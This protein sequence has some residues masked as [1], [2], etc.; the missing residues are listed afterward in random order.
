MSASTSEQSSLLEPNEQGLRTTAANTF[1][2][3]E[4]KSG[5][6]AAIFFL[7]CI[8]VLAAYTYGVFAYG[9]GATNHAQLILMTAYGFI[10]FLRLNLM[11]LWLLKRELAVE[12]LT[13]VILIW[14][15]AILSSFVF[16]LNETNSK[17]VLV[18][19]LA[20]YLFGSFLN[21]YS[22]LERKWWKSKPE[23]QG[24]CYMDGL[25]SWS[26]NINY[27]GDTLL[28][29]GWALA[30]ASWINAWVPVVMGSSFIW[31][32]IPDKETYLAKRYRADW[33]TYTQNTPYAFAPYI[34]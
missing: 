7:E 10:Y 25:F 13:L 2:S 5:I 8:L 27:F 28:F 31:F 18:L 30:T 19:S 32:H 24:R 23:N 22:E 20:I 34:Y 6:R 9:Q 3:V 11:S 4:R 29:A 26:R 16:S 33:T 21:T 1:R 15:P 14:I 17:L 12:E